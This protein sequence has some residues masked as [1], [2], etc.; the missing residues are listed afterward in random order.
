MKNR[1]TVTGRKRWNRIPGRGFNLC[2]GMDRLDSMDVLF[3]FT[4]IGSW[5]LL[6]R[7]HMLSE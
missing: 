5:V 6:F 4:I 7:S 3:W 2:K 1:N